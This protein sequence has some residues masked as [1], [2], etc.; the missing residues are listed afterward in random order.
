MAEAHRRERMIVLAMGA[1]VIK[2]GLNPLIID[3]MERGIVS[4]LALNGA[5]IIHDFELAFIG[6]TSEDVAPELE[7][8]TFGMAEETASYLNGAISKGAAEGIGIGEAVG[9]MILSGGFPTPRTV[10]WPQ[11]PASAFR[12]PFMWRSEP[13]SSICTPRPMGRRLG[14]APISIFAATRRSWPTLREESTSI[15][16]RRSFFPKSF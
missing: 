5:G 15:S 4:A 13:T 8:G 3:L 11:R 10:C 9:K 14:K 16:A 6:Q 7:D 2:V 1:H 12:R